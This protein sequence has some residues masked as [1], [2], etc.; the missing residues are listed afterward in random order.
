[1]GF[2][3]SRRPANQEFIF[4]RWVWK[5]KFSEQGI[6]ITS[7]GY[8]TDCSWGVVKK[9]ER[10]QGMILLYLDTVYAY[11]LPESKLGDP[12]DFYAYIKAQHAN[13]TVSSGSICQA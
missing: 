8:K 10:A 5:F 11:I 6:S 1:M 12:D 3:D 2:T 7:E 13:A 4:I 9:I